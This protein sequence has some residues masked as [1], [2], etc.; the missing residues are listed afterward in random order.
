M[1]VFPIIVGPDHLASDTADQTK[2]DQA[3]A[4]QARAS[5]VSSRPTNRTSPIALGTESDGSV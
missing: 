1:S 5:S 3:R 2:A 4:D